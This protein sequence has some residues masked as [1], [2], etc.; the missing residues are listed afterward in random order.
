LLTWQHLALND[1]GLA[2]LDI[3]DELFVDPLELHLRVTLH[4]AKA[5]LALR[6]IAGIANNRV[7]K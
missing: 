6:V 7:W 1:N 4:K 2:T 3:D 5:C